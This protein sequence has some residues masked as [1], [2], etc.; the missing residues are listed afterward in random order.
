MS[1]TVRRRVGILSSKVMVP[2]LFPCCEIQHQAPP[3]DAS[4][5]AG[6]GLHLRGKVKD[7]HH[8]AI[9]VG[10][11]KRCQDLW[12]KAARTRITGPGSG[13][14]TWTEAGSTYKSCSPAPS[15]RAGRAGNPGR[16]LSRYQVTSTRYSPGA[17]SAGISKS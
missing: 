15:P 16:S 17:A 6:D 3:S 1:R 10:F 12:M 2:R 7:R 9:I 4:T 14:L 8:T 5:N 13:T 11:D